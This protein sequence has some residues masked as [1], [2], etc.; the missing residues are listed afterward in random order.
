VV[1]DG[2]ALVEGGEL[3]VLDFAAQGGLAE[4]DDGAQAGRIEF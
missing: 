3:A 4:Q 2:D 1:S